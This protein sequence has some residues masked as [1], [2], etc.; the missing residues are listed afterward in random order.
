MIIECTE[1]EKELLAQ[2]ICPDCKSSTFLTGPE[3]GGS[4]NILCSQCGAKFNVSPGIPSF[5]QRLTHPEQA[6]RPFDP[7]NL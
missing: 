3:G 7:F 1:A 5:A 4:V 6:P 2:D